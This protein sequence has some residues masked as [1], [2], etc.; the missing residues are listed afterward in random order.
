MRLLRSEVLYDRKFCKTWL[1]DGS[2]RTVRTNRFEPH[3]AAL[4]KD[5]TRQILALALRANH[6]GNQSQL[7]RIVPNSFKPGLSAQEGSKQCI[8]LGYGKSKLDCFSP[9]GSLTHVTR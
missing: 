7:G 3:P 4:A 1:R 5:R 9:F 6:N 8:V 2:A